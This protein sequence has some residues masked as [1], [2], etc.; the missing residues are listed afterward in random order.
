MH[1]NMDATLSLYAI[2]GGKAN[3]Y[4]I[5]TRNNELTLLKIEPDESRFTQ[6]FASNSPKEPIG[7]R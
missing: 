1:R 2:L 5:R 4:Q 7:G 6:R 3:I